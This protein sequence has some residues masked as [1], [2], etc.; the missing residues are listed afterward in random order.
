MILALL[1]LLLYR[2]FGILTF[3]AL[4]VKFGYLIKDRSIEGGDV[5]EVLLMT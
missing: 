5:L 3:S 2:F 1:P 4:P